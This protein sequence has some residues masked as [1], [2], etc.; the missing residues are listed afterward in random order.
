MLPTVN[1]R[2]RAEIRLTAGHWV[3]TII[4]WRDVFETWRQD[5]GKKRGAGLDI[6]LELTEGLKLLED[7]LI[8]GNRGAPESRE[9]LRDLR[10]RLLAA[11]DSERLEILS[12]EVAAEL[13]KE[14]AIRDSETR[15]HRE[16]EVTVERERA[17]FSAWYEMFPRS[18]ASSPGRHGT[19]DDVIARLP[20]VRD[21]GFDV[22]YF[23]PI[24]P[25]G[26][27]HRKGKNNALE[28]A[29]GEPGSPYAIGS[30]AGGHEA[31]HHELG[32]LEDF[33]RL[34]DAAAAV[35]IEIA[36]DF[37][38]QCSPD[39]PW[40]KE[41]PEWFDWR[42]DG[43]LKHAENPPKKYEDIV[44]VHFYDAAVPALWFAWRDIVLL[45]VSRGV[46]IFR[47]DNPHTK[48]FPF[49]EWLIGEVHEHHPEVIF[50]SEAFTRPK[51]MRYLAK[52]GF[53]QSYTYFTWRT[54]KQ[55]MIDY[56]L[57]LTR[58]EARDYMRPNFFTNTPDINPYHLQTGG[59]PAFR[60]RLVMAATLVNSY[61]IYNGFEL[62]EA[63]PIAG[64]EE[65]LDSEKYEI[66]AWDW[67]RPG[68]IKDDIRM[69]NRL[70]RDHPALR[71][72]R[73]IEFY[74]AWN[75]HILYYGKR[76]ADRSDFLLIAVNL[77]PHNPQGAH[78]EVPLWEFGLPDEASIGVEDLLSGR[79]FRWQGKVQ[80][81][82]LDPQERP[83]AIWRLSE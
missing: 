58:S 27:T 60:T 20:Y 15:Y 5:T 34:I 70:R 6:A 38:I 75:D 54:A 53:T 67:D 56:I 42:P 46:R 82:W 16:L 49:W 72:Y 74:N 2:W 30:E 26:H 78:F 28:A 57:E 65:Y 1:D 14:T 36:L 13:F 12:S 10:E 61:G 80:H 51:P 4:A 73:N 47:V 11:S 29:P 68:N 77:D 3:Y 40:I 8:N 64:R 76:T 18:Q 81:M 39:H 33:Q 24:H 55:E 41:H 31:I 32:T 48:P 50:L 7:A 44:N 9:A 62:C 69:I 79:S 19:F 71:A 52:L 59:R 66:K 63:R 17:A 21:L 45:W 83:Y 25:I 35:G 43:S 22:L 37:A 23:P